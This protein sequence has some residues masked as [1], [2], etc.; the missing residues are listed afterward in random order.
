MELKWKVCKDTA[1]RVAVDDNRTDY[2]HHITKR[3]TAFD[4][5][6]LRTVFLDED[7]GEACFMFAANNHVLIVTAVEVN[8]I[9]IGEE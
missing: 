4:R 1:V 3:D 5:N 6:E 8:V 2:R 9:Q 7:T